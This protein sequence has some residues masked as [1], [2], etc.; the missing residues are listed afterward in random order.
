MANRSSLFAKLACA[1]AKDPKEQARLEADLAEAFGL[2][3]D[4]EPAES[5]AARAR[6]LRYLQENPDEMRAVREELAKLQPTE[7][8]VRIDG[9]PA[10]KR[11]WKAAN[12]SHFGSHATGFREVMLSW[13]EKAVKN[14][15]PFDG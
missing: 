9:P 3:D 1:M 13:S 12:G 8:Q 7:L 2:L 6:M 15:R 10:L 4:T 11:L 14:A 5:K